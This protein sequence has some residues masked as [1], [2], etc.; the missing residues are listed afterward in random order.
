M[1]DVQTNDRGEFTDASGKLYHQVATKQP[2][3]NIG[4]YAVHEG[5]WLNCD[6]CNPVVVVS[7]PTETAGGQ[8]LVA[9]RGEWSEAKRLEKEAKERATLATG[10]LKAALAAA[11]GGAL[12]AAL[13]VPG[14]KPMTLTYTEPWQFDMAALKAAEPETYVKYAQKKPGGQWTLAESRGNS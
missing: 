2:P 4:D 10:K 5:P 9:L 6:G 3:Q 11:S 14:F 1:T 12:R 13:H 8:T 7:V